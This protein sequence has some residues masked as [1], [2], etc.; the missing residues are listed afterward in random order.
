EGKA[1][2]WNRTWEPNDDPQET[3]L[4]LGVWGIT[5]ANACSRRGLPTMAGAAMAGCASTRS[6]PRDIRFRY[7]RVG[8]GPFADRSCNP[9]SAGKSP[10]ATGVR[11]DTG[12]V[13][14]RSELRSPRHARTATRRTISRYAGAHRKR[15]WRARK[16][17]AGDLGS[18]NR[19]WRLSASARRHPRAGNAG[20]YR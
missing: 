1:F 10:A 11:A 9:R 18:R 6:F 12:A 16:R 14:A 3:D 7:T 20:L 5:A 15:I 17:R 2:R 19:L 13:F 4:G 8:A